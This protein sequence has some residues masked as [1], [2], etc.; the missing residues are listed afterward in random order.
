MKVCILTQQLGK[1]WSGVGTYSTNLVAGLVEKGIEVVVICPTGMHGDATGAKILEVAMKGWEGKVNYWLPLAWRLSIALKMVAPSERFDLA[2]FTDAR[3][4]LFAPRNLT[5]LAGTVN[6]YYPAACPLNPMALKPYYAEWPAR[7]IYWR[8]VRLLEPIA[9]KKLDAAAANSEYVKQV[10][11]SSYRL[12][13]EKVKVINYGIEEAGADEPVSLDGDPSIL[14]VGAN[15]QRKGLPLLLRALAEVKRSM[16]RVKLHVVGEDSRRAAIEKLAAELGVTANVKFMGGRPNDEVRR[17]KPDMFAMPSLIE[18]FGIVF[19]EAMLTSVPVIGGR[20]GGTLELIDDGRNGF[21]VAPG[22]AEDL[23]RKII[24]LAQDD[25][26][27][28]RFISEGRKT[29][30]KYTVSRMVENT[31]A[32]YERVLGGK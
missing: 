19:L 31:I 10:L 14:F 22:D 29:A 32:L 18:G 6:D 12:D 16:P 5:P 20:T 9:Y 28:K 13:P 27:R 15:F 2:H 8:T 1:R 4:A 17:M 3:E 7:W 23:S 30:S 26:L 25:E 24:R 21:V 11:V